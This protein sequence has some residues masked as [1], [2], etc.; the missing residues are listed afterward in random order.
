[1]ECQ[2]CAEELG[3]T[4]YCL[5]CGHIYCQT[6]ISRLEQ[7]SRRAEYFECPSCRVSTQWS[8]YIDLSKEM[9]CLTCGTEYDP[10]HVRRIF[11]NPISSSAEV[12]TL[13]TR[14]REVEK[15]R[16]DALMEIG[17]LFSSRINPFLQ[18]L[19]AKDALLASKDR[20]LD[21]LKDELTTAKVAL[22]VANERAKQYEAEIKELRRLTS[23][24]SNPVPAS[25]PAATRVFQA[26]ITPDPGRTLV[27]N[28][29]RGVSTSPFTFVSKLP[30]TPPLTPKRPTSTASPLRWATNTTTTTSISSRPEQPFGT[31]SNSPRPSTVTPS[32][33]T[34]AVKQAP[35]KPKKREYKTGAAILWRGYGCPKWT[36]V[37]ECTASDGYH[38]FSGKG[39]NQYATKYTLHVKALNEILYHM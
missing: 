1:M 26:P 23:R 29:S 38:I 13:Q 32:I 16:D 22:G 5:P 3:D 6:C 18:A 39:T 34:R 2:I 19:D 12:L 35:P 25:P 20:T 37:L 28:D 30:A 14:L 7:R 10:E 8:E 27:N 9:K 31:S 17:Q 21:K 36:E 33:Q 11:L 4:A 15:E 24:S